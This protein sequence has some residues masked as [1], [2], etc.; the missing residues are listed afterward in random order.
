MFV[1][2]NLL[3]LNTG[4]QSGSAKLT[5]PGYAAPQDQ[6]CFRL[7]YRLFLVA[8]LKIRMKSYNNEDKVAV[9]KELG[10]LTQM[11]HQLTSKDFIVKTSSNFQV[12]SLFGFSIEL[13]SICVHM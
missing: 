9:V 7:T 1:V 8:A 10:V 6:L 12:M 13:T 4:P 2:G 11:V 5:S 3:Q